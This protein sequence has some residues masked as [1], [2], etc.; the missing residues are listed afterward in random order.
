MTARREGGENKVQE[1]QKFVTEAM[2]KRMS[3]KLSQERRGGKLPNLH[4]GGGVH[5]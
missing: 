3:V 4:G 5:A 2:E 1:Q